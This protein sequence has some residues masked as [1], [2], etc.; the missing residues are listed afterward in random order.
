MCINIVAKGLSSGHVLLDCQSPSH[1][2]NMFQGVICL[3]FQSNL[4]EVHDKGATNAT[5]L[6]YVS[7]WGNGNKGGVFIA[8][9]KFQHFN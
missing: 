1:V 5:W 8:S 2:E 9:M 6:L 3:K 4:D 7:D